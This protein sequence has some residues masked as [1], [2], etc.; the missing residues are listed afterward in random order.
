[1]D[2]P[3]IEIISITVDVK[4]NF[5]RYFDRIKVFSD[6]NHVEQAYYRIDQNPINHKRIYYKNILIIKNSYFFYIL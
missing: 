4:S 6:R 2:L 5:G 3:I 1:M